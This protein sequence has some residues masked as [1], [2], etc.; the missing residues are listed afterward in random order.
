MRGLTVCAPIL[1]AL[2]GTAHAQSERA[3]DP[4]NPPIIPLR[5][6]MRPMGQIYGVT[7]ADPGESLPQARCGVII[8]CLVVMNLTT[9]YDLI[10]F[11]LDVSEPEEA[12]TPRWGPNLFRRSR[13][14]PQGALFTFRSGDQTMCD[15]LVRVEMRDRRTRQRLD[16]VVGSV[17]LCDDGTHQNVMLPIRVLEPRVTLEPGE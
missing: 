7:G 16:N 6:D 14:G 13:I 1:I 3:F 10:G 12:G 5:A 8:G 11:Y 9:N 15:R 4:W 17:S 2:A